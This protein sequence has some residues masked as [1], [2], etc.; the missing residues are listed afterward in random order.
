[1]YVDDVPGLAP[2]QLAGALP[3]GDTPEALNEFWQTTRQSAWS[4]L[5]NAA[6]HWFAPRVSFRRP[7]MQS[8][9]WFGLL[10]AEVEPPGVAW[11]GWHLR[12]QPDRAQAL[13]LSAVEAYATV[14]GPLDLC[15][16]RRSDGRVLHEATH[17]LTPGWNRLPLVGEWPLDEDHAELLLLVR[18]AVVGLYPRSLSPAGL[19]SWRARPV[20]V[21]RLPDAAPLVTRAEQTPG[22]RWQGQTGGSVA[23]VLATQAAPLASVW[24]LALAVECLQ[25]LRNSPRLNEHTRLEPERL[26]QRQTELEQAFQQTLGNHLAALNLPHSPVLADVRQFRRVNALP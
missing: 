18:S 6:A 11:Q 22:L 21:E 26:H 23:A 3:A 8:P 24:Q 2:V 4:R 14:A 17:T 25:A 13:E 16:L 9:A 15:L 7:L 12:L 10:R 1:L 19:H 5:Q 20:V